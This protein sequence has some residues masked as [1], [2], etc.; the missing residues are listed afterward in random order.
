M[1]AKAPKVRK[2]YLWKNIKSKKVDVEF[3]VLQEFNFSNKKDYQET[4]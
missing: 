2:K 4:C 1:D 3:T